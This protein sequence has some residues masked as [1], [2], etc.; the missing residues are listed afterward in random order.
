MRYIVTGTDGKLA[1]RIAE[2][3]LKEVNPVDL[4]FTCP[5]IENLDPEKKATWEKLG[6]TVKQGNYN[7]VEE[8]TQ[9]FEGGD[10]I[11]IVS[12]VLLGEARVQ[13]HKNVVD[14]AIAAGVKHI[15][16]TSCVGAS[17]PAYAHVYVTPDH[18]ATETY[19]K[20]KT[21]ETGIYYNFM[22]NN[23]YLENYLTVGVVFAMMSGNKWYT[24]AG[25]GK[26]T[27]IPKD[28]SARVGTALLLGKGEN[29]TAYNICGHESISQRELAEIISEL[30]G[31]QI[32]YC[33]VN[34][35]AFYEHL[36]SLNIPR[37]W[38]GDFSKSPVPWCSNDMVT[39]EA[40]IAEGLMNVISDD[41]EKLT[42]EKPKGVKE[43]ANN[44]SYIWE[45]RITNW[46]DMK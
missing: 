40:S 35:E 6:V 45:Q 41:V 26:A 29:N 21:A 44:F 22:R 36:D 8:M 23:L 3:M 5:S 16:Y 12:G 10:R 31:I 15:T 11:Y 38:N 34:H 1:G 9:A 2:N 32:E 33:P 20:E 37:D 39:N 19:I 25:E 17:D 7:N 46:K 14:A 27:F 13:Q 30:S 28:D 24:T 4:I 43:I 18:T 42:G